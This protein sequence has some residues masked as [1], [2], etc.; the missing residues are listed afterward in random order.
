MV[1]TPP[2]SGRQYDFADGLY[3]GGFLNK[4]PTT[5]VRVSDDEI[6]IHSP[7]KVVVTAPEVDVTA[8][9]VI[10][11]QAPTINL[12]GTVA[13]TAGPVT[14]AETLE[15][16]SD[17]IIGGGLSVAGTTTGA[18]GAT[19]TGDVTADGTSVHNHVHANVTNGPG[20]TV[21]PAVRRNSRCM[22]ERDANG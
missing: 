5:Y 12:K 17:V 19:F 10:N 15:V 20:S 16:S 6:E 14:M 18:G 3:L 4:V 21:K 7:V 9:T 22:R 13:Q 8:G 11:L 2:G 1:G